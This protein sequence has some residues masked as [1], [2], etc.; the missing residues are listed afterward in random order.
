MDAL[1]VLQESER[2][3][4]QR[5]RET[6]NELLESR[7]GLANDALNRLKESKG[8]H[9][10]PIVLALCNR[11]SGG[12]A[13]DDA[14][15]MAAVIELLHTASLVHDDVIDNSAL[16]RGDETLNALYTNHIAVLVGDYLLATVFDFGLQ[17]FSKEMLH[18]IARTGRNLCEGELLQ[19]AQSRRPEA[20]SMKSYFDIIHFKTASLFEVSAVLGGKIAGADDEAMLRLYTVGRNIGIAFQ[21]GD[22]IL[23]YSDGSQSGKPA[24]NDLAEGKVTLPLLY[25]LEQSDDKQREELMER[26]R[27]AQQ[28]EAERNEL[29]HY[30]HAHGGIAYAQKR[31]SLY[32]EEAKRHLSAFPPCEA[33]N[34]LVRLVDWLEQRSY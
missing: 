14:V 19:F 30:T 23:D 5:F 31:M 18:M 33:R 8:K 7:I 27:L 15:R 1:T 4:L 12:S 25:L 11:L 32:T 2:D 16:R 29:I 17:H 21:I 20:L 26:I 10:R 3:F 28:G 9:I 13:G 24:G 6:F 22:D 34:L